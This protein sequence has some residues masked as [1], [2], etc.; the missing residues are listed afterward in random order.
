M[1]CMAGSKC[2]ETRL[3]YYRITSGMRRQASSRKFSDRELGSWWPLLIEGEAP[4]P[5]RVGWRV[6][7]DWDAQSAYFEILDAVGAVSG[8]QVCLDAFVGDEVW[9]GAMDVYGELQRIG[10]G[11]LPAAVRGMLGG[12]E[13]PWAT[14]LVN[15]VVGPAVGEAPWLMET[16]ISISLAVALA[17]GPG[18]PGHPA[19]AA[20]RKLTR[21]TVLLAGLQGAAR[22]QT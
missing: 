7:G 10:G 16:E 19:V 14:S 18:L 17:A 1:E 22:S 6:R 9:S 15:P 2:E 11:G 3:T 5:G 20:T 12:A 4:L 13:A 21:P 8:L